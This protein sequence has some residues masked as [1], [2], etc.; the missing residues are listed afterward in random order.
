ILIFLIKRL[1]AGFFANNNKLVITPIARP[2]YFGTFKHCVLVVVKESPSTVGRVVRIFPIYLTPLVP[3]ILPPSK[4]FNG[5]KL[6][7][8]KISPFLDHVMQQRSVAKYCTEINYRS[9]F[10][11]RR[12]H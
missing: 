7:R 6:S 8:I 10:S 2:K 1:L 11:E 5:R 3:Q 9:A 12:Y 4:R